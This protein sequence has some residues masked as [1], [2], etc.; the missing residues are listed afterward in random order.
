MVL[1]QEDD[2]D[3]CRTFH[4][5]TIMCKVCTQR[6]YGGCD[7]YLWLSRTRYQVPTCRKHYQTLPTCEQA[8]ASEICS[9]LLTTI[10]R[11]AEVEQKPTDLVQIGRFV[12]CH[13]IH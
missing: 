9:T 4:A 11:V 2:A 5:L 6:V 7:V 13:A 10:S 12:A 3:M 1:G 8:C